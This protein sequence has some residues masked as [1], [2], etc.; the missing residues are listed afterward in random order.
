MKDIIRACDF[1]GLE[2]KFHSGLNSKSFK[3]LYGGF[4]SLLCIHGV[5]GACIYFFLQFISRKNLTLMTNIV[6]SENVAITNFQDYPIFFKLTMT[7]AK[8]IDNPNRVW[9]ATANLATLDPNLGTTY[10]RIYFNVEPCN[11]TLHFTK[12]SDLIALSVSDFSSYYCVNWGNT[13]L[14]FTGSYGSASYNQFLNVRIRPCTVEAND[15]NCLS[16]KEIDPILSDAY[17]DYRTLDILIDNNSINVQNEYIYG[18]R[19]GLSYTVFRRLF[20]YYKE[21]QYYSDFGLIFEEKSTDSF[22]QF[23]SYRTETDIRVYN[24]LNDLTTYKVFAWI[25]IVLTKTRVIYQRSYLKAQSALAN[26]GGIIQ[27]LLTVG[28]ILNYP[29]SISLFETELCNSIVLENTSS[30]ISSKS[31]GQGTKLSMNKSDNMTIALGSSQIKLDNESA[32]PKVLSPCPQIVRNQE[33]PQANSDSSGNKKVKKSQKLELSFLEILVPKACYCNKEEAKLKLANK[34]IN[35]FKYIRMSQEFSI[36]K[37][38][39]FESRQLEIINEYFNNINS[40]TTDSI[41][42]IIESKSEKP[43]VDSKLSRIIGSK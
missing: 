19:I 16:P 17:L 27:V 43:M 1:Y 31:F 23:D 37:L 8:Q 39:Y 9:K 13:T 40:E 10:T 2:V 38:C 41:K 15:Q 42:A 7:S 28:T 14:N 21:I 6:T 20:F 18:D 35:I 32:R 34:T 24:N 12:Y 22:N 11:S 5:L 26:L 25:N 33:I 4:V 29:V 30:E 3:S 36:L